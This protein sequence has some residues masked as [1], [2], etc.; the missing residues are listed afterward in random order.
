[1]RSIWD[2]EHE[3]T[4]AYYQKLGVLSLTYKNLPPVGSL[5][6]PQLEF[7][8]T[9]N[10]SSRLG[11]PIQKAWVHRW[12]GGT[13][14]SVED[15]FDN[16]QSEASATSVYAGEVGK[17][18]GRCVQMV[19]YS[20]KAWT[21]AFYN[22]T[23]VSLECGDAMWL[24]HDPEGFA[25]A[26]RIIAFWCHDFKLPDNWVHGWTLG[27][28]G[29]LR[30]ADGGQLAGGHTS[31]PTTDLNLWRQFVGRVKDEHEYGR[32]RKSWGIK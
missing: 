32:F 8:L 23:G 14:Q 11:A 4:I 25:R 26:A 29:F 12:A 9:A 3:R 6:L 24:G 10:S 1:L 19:R 7:N 17:A 5:T 15:W 30:H 16:P 22:R 27:R 31:C 21:E 18:A 13:F 28:K 20:R 2:N